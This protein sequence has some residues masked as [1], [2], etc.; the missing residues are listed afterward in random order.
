M[1]TDFFHVDSRARFLEDPVR[2]PNNYRFDLPRLLRSVREIEVFRAEVPASM[3]NITATA[4]QFAFTVTSPSVGTETFSFGIPPG[5]YTL[6]TAVVKLNEIKNALPGC[7]CLGPLLTFSGDETTGKISLTVVSPGAN[8]KLAFHPYYALGIDHDVHGAGDSSQ[9]VVTSPHP[10]RLN[11]PTV[12]FLSFPNIRAI[13]T[14]SDIE[15]HSGLFGHAKGHTE[16]HVSRGCITARMQLTAGQWNVNYLE[17]ETR[18]YLRSF[19]SGAVNLHHL[20]VLFTDPLGR[21]V[22]FNGADHSLFLRIA[23]EGR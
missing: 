17:S 1:Y 16:G 10:V 18:V 23:Y 5:A 9:W 15:V 2:A 4:G 6:A 12:L 21:L 22:D 3:Y 19:P 7:G 11:T 20:D 8:L 14:S 13:G